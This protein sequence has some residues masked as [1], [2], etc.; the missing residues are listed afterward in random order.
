MIHVSSKF[1]KH[2]DLLERNMVNEFWRWE[3]IERTVTSFASTHCT[4]VYRSRSFGLN[5]SLS[6]CRASNSR[7]INRRG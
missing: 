7:L 2:P 1:F 4:R 5:E 3:G 6:T